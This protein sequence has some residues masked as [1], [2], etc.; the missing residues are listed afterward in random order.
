VRVECSSRRAAAELA[1]KLRAEG[2][3]NVQRFNYVVVGARDE[4]SAEALARRLR[5]EA[6]EGSVVRA[7]GTLAS[8]FTSV[9]TASPFA[10]F[11]G[12]G[13]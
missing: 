6:P 12:V 13:G 10:I 11:G 7:E 5:A 9:R 4:D 1:D 2:L 8:A 3:P